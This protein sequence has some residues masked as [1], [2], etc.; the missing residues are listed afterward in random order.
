MNAAAN[1][2]S[3]YVVDG[4]AGI[5]PPAN[6]AGNFRRR[7]KVSIELHRE[8]QKEK[9]TRKHKFSRENENVGQ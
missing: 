4:S 9:Q 5:S 8:F 3:I 6:A 2:A 7:I 1:T